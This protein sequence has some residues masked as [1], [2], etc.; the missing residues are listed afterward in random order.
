MHRFLVMLAVFTGLAVAPSARAAAP[1]QRF[2]IVIGNGS[3]QAKILP[4][5]VND[6]ALVAQTLKAAGF[7]VTGLRDLNGDML[8]ESFRNFFAKVK[9]AGPDAIVA[10]Y[11]AGLGLQLDGENYLLPIDAEIAKPSDLRR[12]ALAL[13]GLMH[14]LAALHLKAGFV[15][16]DAARPI[17][18]LVSGQPP[19]SG[20]AWTEPEVN[21]LVAFNAAPGTDAPDSGGEASYGPYAL[22]LVEMIR[23]GGLAPATLFD[24][25]RLRVIQLT[26][27][28][29]V[30]WDAS[31][32]QTN[33]TFL[34]RSSGAPP[35]ADAPERTAWMRALGMRKLS[36]GDAYWTALLR[37]TFDGYAEFVAQ[38]WHDPMTARVLAMLAVRREALTWQRTRQANVAEAY[39]TYLER[40]PRGPHG[41]DA[42]RLLRRLGAATAP[43]ANFKRQQYD[44]PPPLPD[45][46]GYVQQTVL[47]FN[48]PSFGFAPLQPVPAYFLEPQP[49]ELQHLAPPVDC[50]EGHGLPEVASLSLPPYVRRPAGILAPPKRLAVARERSAVGCTKNVRSGAANG[51]IAPPSQAALDGANGP[52]AKSTA[53]LIYP[54]WV[55]SI[56]PTATLLTSPFAMPAATNGPGSPTTNSP[57]LVKRRVSLSYPSW[58][59]PAIVPPTPDRSA[60]PGSS[61]SLSVSTGS[62]SRP[63]STATRNPAN[64]HATAR[65]P[66]PIPRR[67]MLSRP[68]S[69]SVSRAAL[70][71]EQHLPIHGS[72][73]PR[74]V[75]PSRPPIG[76]STP[77]SRRGPR[78]RAPMRLPSADAIAR[79]PS[80]QAKVTADAAS[81]R[82][83]TDVDRMKRPKESSRSQPPRRRRSSLMS[84]GSPPD[85]STCIVENGDLICGRRDR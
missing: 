15:I 58:V 67:M 22:A 49:P 16:V 77:V 80:R 53:S 32:I 38:Y 20:L 62:L 33:F 19:A 42:Q 35:R 1:E 29:Q 73:A 5:A 18:F 82:V 78:P 69:G 75:V 2:A 31:M 44:V 13:S 10:I 25:V 83:R 27:G 28:A 43:P 17:P 3:Y 4:T 36:A 68:P 45:E 63:R 66:L 24:R 84:S 12:H 11:F 47:I 8:R 21:T 9:N 85:P 60:R 64:A 48:D 57:P 6:A 41:K 50:P 55:T 39:W 56:A 65:I 23:E 7:D 30:P 54:S 71:D 70:R 34:A 61:P 40:Y 76:I 74:R 46:L 14:A 52:S 59:T 81:S 37:D 51:P 26:N 72:A 79:P